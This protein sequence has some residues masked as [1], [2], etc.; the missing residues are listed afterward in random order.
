M[1]QKKWYQS[2]TIYL[3]LIALL[4]II[5]Q[6]SIGIEI[7]P[8]EYQATIVAILNLITRT[9]TNSNITV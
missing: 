4:L 3:N 6:S 1:L 5:V 8:V 7:I 9:I 2:K